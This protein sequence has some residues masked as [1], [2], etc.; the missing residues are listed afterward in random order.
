MAMSCNS[1]SHHHL[2]GHLIYLS[3]SSSFWF[4]LW[5]NT[6]IQIAESKCGGT[7]E[8]AKCIT[9]HIHLIVQAGCCVASRHAAISSSRRPLAAP[10]SRRLIAQAGCCIASRCATVSSSCRA[11]TLTSPS[12]TSSPSPSP[13]SLP[14]SIACHPRCH[15]LGCLFLCSGI[16]FLVPK[17]RS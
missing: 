14:P 5:V 12:P 13:S 15:H 4:S 17:N 3:S 10:P 1:I 7:F 16:Y 8:S 11:A 2:A 6:A 9:N